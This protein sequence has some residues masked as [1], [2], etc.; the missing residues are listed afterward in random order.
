MGKYV[1]KSEYSHDKND[2]QKMDWSVVIT[3]IQKKLLLSQNELA[4]K[5]GIPQQT[6][7]GWVNYSRNPGCNSK[8]KLIEFALKSGVE[9][10]SIKKIDSSGEI[11]KHTKQYGMQTR[12]NLLLSLFEKLKEPDKQELM[13]YALFKAQRSVIASH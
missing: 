3:E 13:D 12:E 11:S 5:S 8:R 10:E 4:K 7:S 9:I 6:I 1:K 2:V